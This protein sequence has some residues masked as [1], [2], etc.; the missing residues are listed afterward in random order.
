MSNVPRLKQVT[1]IN[2]SFMVGKERLL[3]QLKREPRFDKTDVLAGR[4]AIDLRVIPYGR[5]VL[6]FFDWSKKKGIEE[7]DQHFSS[8][9]FEDGTI[10]FL[11]PGLGVDQILSTCEKFKDIAAKVFFIFSKARLDYVPDSYKDKF[12][13]K[14]YSLSVVKL[15]KDCNW[16]TTNTQA[17]V[18]KLQPVNGGV[19]PLDWDWLKRRYQMKTKDI[20]F[21]RDELSVKRVRVNRLNRALLSL[22]RLLI[23][24][25][26]ATDKQTL[27]YEFNFTE[28][29]DT[30]L[31]DLKGD[32]MKYGSDWSFDVAEEKGSS[33]DRFKRGLVTLEVKINDENLICLERWYAQVLQT[34]KDQDEF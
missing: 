1:L 3:F 27:V 29:M 17:Q 8:T 10:F 30:L 16:V 23:R 22:N 9:N 4:R 13:S 11:D 20:K 15:D 25:V 14:G 18:E 24:T 7:I 28:E 31:Y 19:H 33:K 32:L 21:T 34:D 26:E 5:P 6:P 2:H 12:S